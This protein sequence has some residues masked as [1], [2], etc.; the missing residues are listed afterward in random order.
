MTSERHAGG[1]TL[2]Q[3]RRDYRVDYVSVHFIQCYDSVK[4]MRNEWCH[5]TRNKS[6]SSIQRQHERSGDPI[7]C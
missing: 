5:A 1:G 6:S 3:T 4:Q 2:Q 7:Y